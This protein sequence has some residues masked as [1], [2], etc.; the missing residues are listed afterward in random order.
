MTS[1]KIEER[2]GYLLH[3]KELLEDAKILEEVVVV[4]YGKQSEKLLTTS[5]SSMKVDVKIVKTN[6]T[7]TVNNDSTL[8]DVS[9]SVNGTAI[10]ATMPASG[11]VF[12]V[13]V[14]AKG[15]E[16]PSHVIFNGSKKNL[17]NGVFKE[18]SEDL[19]YFL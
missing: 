12:T 16:K 1:I 9:V 13:K 8:A 3:N 2:E 19:E 14:T 17:T 4:G 10:G 7:L 5:I 15:E 11:T 18:N 6:A